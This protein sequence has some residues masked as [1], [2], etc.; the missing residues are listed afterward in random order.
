MY[1]WQTAQGCYNQNI[2]NN[3]IQAI[4]KY[5]NWRTISEAYLKPFVLQSYN[6]SYAKRDQFMCYITYNLIEANNKRERWV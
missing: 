3:K 6:I 4:Y 5:K 2:T 1:K